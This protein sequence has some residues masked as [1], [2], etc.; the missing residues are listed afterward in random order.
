MA[1]RRQPGRARQQSPAAAERREPGK[2]FGLSGA[3]HV[4]QRKPA[5][6]GP[7]SPNTA[8]PPGLTMAEAGVQ[9]PK[10]AGME[11]ARRVAPLVEENL[12][13]LG[14]A[15]YKRGVSRVV[16]EAGMEQ[17]P[18][19]LADM[20]EKGLSPFKQM[21]R[22]GAFGGNRNAPLTTEGVVRGKAAGLPL[23]EETWMSALLE[24]MHSNK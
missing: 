19:A 23:Q 15:A 9:G 21:E 6:I 20:F 11:L 4:E 10:G 17:G 13:E 18:T 5:L 12:P 2:V 14:K 7:A 22:S 16:P 8:F 1:K 24:L 3:A